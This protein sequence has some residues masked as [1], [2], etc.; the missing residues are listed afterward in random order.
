MLY[1]SH[2][3]CSCS[4]TII[5]ASFLSDGYRHI[6]GSNLW[7]DTAHVH[8]SVQTDKNAQEHHVDEATLLMSS[9]GHD[10]TSMCWPFCASR[11]HCS[12][13]VSL[14]MPSSMSGQ[15]ATPRRNACNKHTAL[16][17]IY[18][19]RAA[20]GTISNQA[21]SVASTSW[22]MSIKMGHRL[23][24]AGAC[25]C[26]QQMYHDSADCKQRPSSS[27]T[28][29]AHKVCQYTCAVSL[30][31][32]GEETAAGSRQPCSQHHHVLPVVLPCASAA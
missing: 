24:S 31:Y 11:R 27:T 17:S 22:C 30:V 16:T 25:K 26:K 15:D 20:W 19:G 2:V 18:M 32:K 23:Q 6:L 9:T 29:A 21:D 8:S 12:S 3:L 4:Q 13:G 7:L 10:V 28:E 14:G 1:T 5:A